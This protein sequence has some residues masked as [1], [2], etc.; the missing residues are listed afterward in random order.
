MKLK[1]QIA[2]NAKAVTLAKYIDYQNAVDMV[3]KVHVI[4]GKSTESIRLMHLNVLEEIVMRFEAAIV[5]GSNTFERRVRIGTIELGFIPN[6][7]ELTFGEYIDLDSTC[8]NLYKDGKVNG[9]AAFKMLSILY[10]P[11]KAKFGKYYDIEKYDPNGKR[12]YEDAVMQLTL[13]HVLNVLL[14]FS[15][16]EIELYS[17]SLE[18]LAKEIT[19][20]VKEMTPVPPQMD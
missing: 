3:E 8:T 13:D 4:T 18:Y 15:S 2:A 19:E 16:L 11:I 5:L 12:R 9:E 6:L 7:N 1:V 14:F 10:R 17:S 20:I